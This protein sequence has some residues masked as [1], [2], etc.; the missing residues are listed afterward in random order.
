MAH[1]LPRNADERRPVEIHIDAERCARRDVAVESEAERFARHERL[2]DEVGVA[3][4]R[5]FGPQPQALSNDLQ[6][7]AATGLPEGAAAARF[8]DVWVLFRSAKHL[9]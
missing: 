6:L 4:D 5:A 7:R 2:R 3:A 1:G 8:V 9:C